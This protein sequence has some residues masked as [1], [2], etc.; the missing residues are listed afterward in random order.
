MLIEPAPQPLKIDFDHQW[1]PRSLDECLHELPVLASVCHANPSMENTVR[2]CDMCRSAWAAYLQS[3]PGED[4]NGK[5]G[6]LRSG[7]SDCLQ[8]VEAAVGKAQPADRAVIRDYAGNIRFR[9][10][11]LGVLLSDG[12]V[13]VQAEMEKHIG[14]LKSKRA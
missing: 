1:I 2:A 4:A 12:D 10:H 6:L 14:E 13:A 7:L 9:L 8:A 3:W 11:L 5:D